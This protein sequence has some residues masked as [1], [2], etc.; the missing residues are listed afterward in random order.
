MD[1][2]K[3]AQNISWIGILLGAALLLFVGLILWSVAESNNLI[4]FDLDSTNSLISWIYNSILLPIKDILWQ[5]AVPSNLTD[6]NQ[7]IIAFAVFLLIWLIGTKS[8]NNMFNNQVISFFVAMLVATIAGRALTSTIIEQYIQGSPLAS[9]VAL[10]GILPIFMFY[11]F[12]NNWTD[13]KYI[14][15]LGVWIILAITYLIVFMQFDASAMGTMYSTFILIA[16]AFDIFTPIIKH[17]FQ[18]SKRK[19]LG[20]FMVLTHRDLETWESARDAA[21]AAGRNTPVVPW[22]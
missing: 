3:R 16:G 17:G 13:G 9:G 2:N 14:Y 18:T 6:I 21:I 10:I 8:L 15:K 1:M 22:R 19:A 11:G 7:E 12:I 5:I 20:N 4:N